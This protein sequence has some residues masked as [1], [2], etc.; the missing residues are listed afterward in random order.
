VADG[1][2][3]TTERQSPVPTPITPVT[4]STYVGTHS[5]SVYRPSF[6]RGLGIFSISLGAVLLLFLVGLL[7]ADRTLAN[8]ARSQAEADASEVAALLESFISTRTLKLRSFRGLFASGRPDTQ[9]QFAA[10]ISEMASPAIGMQRVWVA[11]STGY[12]VY[13]TVLLATPE[14]HS[15][16]GEETALIERARQAGRAQLGRPQGVDPISR[17][18]ALVEPLVLSSRVVGFAGGRLLAS[19]LPLD[20]RSEHQATRVGIALIAARDTIATNGR[21]VGGPAERLEERRVS[22]VPPWRVVVAHRE[23][24]RYVRFTLWSLGILAIA[25]LATGFRRER[26]QAEDMAKRSTQLEQL[27]REVRD[28]SRIKSEFLANVSHELRTPLNAIVGFVE[29]LRDGVYGELGPRQG[30]PV[31]RIAA[32]A[33]HLRHLVDQVLDIAKMAAGRLE[34][35]PEPIVLRPFVLNIVSELESLINEKGLTLSIT[36]G[37]TLPRVRTDPTHLRQIVVN[38]VGNAVKYTTTG[39]IAVRA[40]LIGPVSPHPADSSLP[41]S[42]TRRNVPRPEEEGSLASIAALAARAPRADRPWLALQVSDTGIG[43]APED[44]ER[45]F[46]EFEQ[47]NAGPR[48]DSMRRGTGLGLSISRRLARLLGADLTVESDLGRGSTFTLWLPVDPA[49][50]EARKTPAVPTAT[51]G[52][53]SSL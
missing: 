21:L 32:S 17:S 4:G 42:N 36:V 30:Q 48:G 26:R 43:I 37:T 19:A 50:L 2:R 23:P 8:A 9:A 5:G 33:S 10:M 28:A 49:D 34:V 14:V 6:L 29:M 35:H 51:V 40:R 52:R 16:A 11:D 41:A 46:E 15:A 13:D 53:S 24:S 3:N 47:V 18:L 27:Y 31:E 12:V 1:S 45:I 38:L 20:M 22:G 39:G 7:V 25:F 44:Q